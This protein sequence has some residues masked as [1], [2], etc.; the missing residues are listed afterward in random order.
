M[1][2]KHIDIWGNP[3]E[4]KRILDIARKAFEKGEPSNPPRIGKVKTK[5]V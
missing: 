4:G 2:E 1:E 5:L 3:E